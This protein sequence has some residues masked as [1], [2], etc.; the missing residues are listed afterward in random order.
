MQDVTLRP[1]RPED[2]VSV[3]LLWQHCFTVGA[4]PATAYVENLCGSDPDGCFLVEVDA[5]P[6]GFGCV[7]TCGALGYLG[8]SGVLKEYRGHGYG[9]ALIEARVAY[10]RNRCSVIGL[11]TYPDNGN[12][13]GRN[14]H[15]GFRETL[16]AREIGKNAAPEKPS[17]PLPDTIRSGRAISPA[18]YDTLLTHIRS[19]TERILP[20]LDFSQDIRLFLTQYPDHI[21]F[22][23]EDGKPRGFIAQHDNFRGDTWFAIAPSAD[24]AQVFD[25]LALAW[26]Q[27][28]WPNGV[29]YHFH[30]NAHRITP[31]LLQRGYRVWRDLAS[32]V[33]H[34][35][36][37]PFLQPS[38]ALFGRPWWS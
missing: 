38:S 21:L 4:P 37:G 5:A 6:V 15:L 12:T 35:H 27:V 30:T 11:E 16:P 36:A 32:M 8:P 20:G 19:W 17:Q 14:Y 2:Y 28:N 22:F 10:L 33:L 23:V 25:A 31:F 3:G 1:I 26:E 7:H 13:I 18:D 29:Y 34:T 9:K 24:D